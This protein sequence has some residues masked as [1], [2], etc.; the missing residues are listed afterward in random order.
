MQ[1]APRLRVRIA[2]PEPRVRRWAHCGVDAPAAVARKPRCRW[3]PDDGRVGWGS[4]IPG[5]PTVHLQGL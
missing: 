4:P 1:N 3:G 5:E 2:A